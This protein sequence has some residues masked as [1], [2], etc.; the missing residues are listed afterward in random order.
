MKQKVLSALSVAL[1]V[2][3]VASGLSAYAGL[4]PAKYLPV[5]AIAFAVVS[6]TKDFVIHLQSDF[7]KPDAK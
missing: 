6:S 5:S 3:S 7:S 4:I 2:L 1:K